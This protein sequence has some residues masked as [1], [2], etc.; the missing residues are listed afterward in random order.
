MN[1]ILFENDPGFSSLENGGTW[2][3][4]TSKMSKDFGP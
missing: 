1:R 4:D 2:V 3:R